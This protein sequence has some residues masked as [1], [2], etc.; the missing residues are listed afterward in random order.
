MSTLRSCTDASSR[1]PGAG[2]LPDNLAEAIA[3]VKPIREA[4]FRCDLPKRVAAHDHQVLSPSDS[5]PYHILTRGTAKTG[6][7]GALELT[8]T[9]LRNPGKISRFNFCLEV[10]GNI[11]LDATGLPQLYEFV[12]SPH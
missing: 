1:T 3:E 5:H 4:A 6:A 12:T 7:E 11:S 8:A 9:E 2:A 10:N